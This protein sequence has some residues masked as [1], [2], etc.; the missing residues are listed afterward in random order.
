MTPMIGAMSDNV[1]NYQAIAALPPFPLFPISSSCPASS[2]RERRSPQD[3]G[4]HR[5]SPVEQFPK[6]IEI[7]LMSPTKKRNPTMNH[8]FRSLALAISMALGIVG[9]VA[10][11]PVGAANAHATTLVGTFK[12]TAGSCAT[13]HADR[14]VLPHDLSRREPHGGKFFDNPDSTC[15]DKSYTL[16]VPGTAGG[17]TTGKYQPEPGAGLLGDGKRPVEH[18]HPTTVVHGHQLQHRHESEGSPDR[19]CRT[20]A[21]DQGQEREALGTGRGVERIMEQALLQS[22][23]AQARRHLAWADRAGHRDLQ[24]QDPRLRADVGSAVVGGPF[25]GFTGY[26]HLQ[27]KFVPSKK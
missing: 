9:M 17:F 27:G 2:W 3:P 12:L 26:W 15:T 23:L 13:T 4:V 1:A 18:D 5:R 7:R 16:A 24:L 20:G 21:D 14:D 25:N 19:S 6:D 11:A 10:T 22:G 8:R